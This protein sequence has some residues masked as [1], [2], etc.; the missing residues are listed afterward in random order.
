MKKNIAIDGIKKYLFE[1]ISKQVATTT[2]AVVR[3][4]SI[5]KNYSFLKIFLKNFEKFTGKHLCYS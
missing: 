4:C 2:K 5:K 1:E 3:R